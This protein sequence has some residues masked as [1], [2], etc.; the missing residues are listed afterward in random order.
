MTMVCLILSD[1][2][3]D[4]WNYAT[5]DGKSI[6]KGIEYMYPYVNDKATWPFN[7]DV[8]YWD[9]WPVAH[10]FLLFGASKFNQQ[11][12]YN[13]WTTLEHFPQVEEVIRNLPVRNP[14][15]WFE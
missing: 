15:L 10:P 2:E 7:H 13:T 4:L 14:V 8:M 12:W 6:R 1:K 3:N 11:S 5:P 9:N